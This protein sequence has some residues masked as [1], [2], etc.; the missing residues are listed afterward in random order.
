[1]MLDNSSDWRMPERASRM[2][3]LTVLVVLSISMLSSAV[4]S[5]EPQTK[6]VGVSSL[7]GSPQAPQP[8]DLTFYMHNTT[9]ARDVDG[10][11][12]PYVF[13]TAQEFGGN[14]T[15]SKLQ[16]VKQD[17][18]LFPTLASNLTVNGSISLHAFASVSLVNS[19]INPSLTI[20][21]VNSSGLANWSQTQ[22]YGSVPWWADP[23][24]LNLTIGN[25]HH[26]FASGSTILVLVDIVSGSRIVTI[27]YNSSWVPTHLLI[28]SDDFAQI[29]NIAT[30]DASST[31]RVSFDPLA[32][33]TTVDIVVNVTDPLGGYDIQWVNLTM[34]RPGGGYVLLDAPMSKVAGTPL[35]YVSTYELAWNYSGQPIG[36]YNLTA[37]VLDNSGYHHFEEFYATDGFLSHLDA[38]FFIGGLPA[39]VNVKVVDSQGSSLPAATVVLRSAGVTVDSKVTDSTGRAD[40]TMV[41][42]VYTFEVIWE[43]IQVASQLQNVTENVTSSNPLTMTCLVFSPT[44]QAQDA[45]GV[46]LPDASLLFTHPNG[47]KIGP[48]KTNESGMV[49]LDQVPEGSYG[50][51]VAWRGVGV[52]HGTES[53]SANSLISVKVNV[54]ELTVTAKAG[55]GKAVPGAFIS[56]V[57]SQGLVY[58]AGVTGSN[59]TTVLRLPAGS[60]SL[61][62]R[63][64]TSYDGSL[65]DSGMKTQQVNLTQSSS[66]TVTFGNFP[67][68]LTSTLDFLFALVYAITVVAL[69][70]ALFLVWRRGGRGA[71]KSNEVPGQKKV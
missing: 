63:Y 13:D 47:T 21:E 23:H 53:V 19:N 24:D 12:T 14:N 41:K 71:G 20:S 50:L 32:E 6:S 60:Y 54:F 48:Y 67:I 28:Q 9:L 61:E 44:F 66:V 31:P 4:R 65:Y 25:V 1:M 62:S 27:W 43:G 29:G 36:K 3:A 46:Y 55:D 18:Y 15:V 64:I 68:S 56:V 2:L 5:T 39:Y 52:F 35:S 34:E 70:L 37:D 10:I 16:E 22:N 30:M 17:W 59:G 40:L 57:D 49:A 42:G 38:Y 58:D 8:R 69:L 45:A 33:N 51:A 7:A 26:T 11:S